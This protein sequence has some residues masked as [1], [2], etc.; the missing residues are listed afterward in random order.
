[1]EEATPGGHRSFAWGEAAQGIV[2]GRADR[3]ISPMIFW[4]DI[5]AIGVATV[6]T[7]GLGALVIIPNVYP[8]QEPLGYLAGTVQSYE[9]RVG[10][11]SAR[12]YFD[13]KLDRGETMR[14]RSSGESVPGDRI[15]V[16][17]V[18]RGDLV[19]GYLVPMAKCQSG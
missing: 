15:C 10:K 9:F 12:G 6:V 14:V 8:V 2:G 4:R 19:E 3:H 13:V 5:L 1:L 17:A 11:I 18:R 16:R 7:A